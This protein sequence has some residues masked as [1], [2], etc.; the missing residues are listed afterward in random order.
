MAEGLLRHISNGGIEVE[1][2]GTHPSRV[3]PT[4]IKVM[5]E[6]G[7]DISHHTSKSINEFI[8]QQ[9]DYVITVCD[10]ARAVCPAFPGA[11]R[12]LHFPFEDPVMFFGDEEQQLGK[13][14]KIRDEIKRRMTE[15]VA[16]EITR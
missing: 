9:F 12:S 6:I 2:A 14:R 1:S 16:E 4:A 5:N 15:F 3:H 8:G 11:R 13:F 7:I 10:H